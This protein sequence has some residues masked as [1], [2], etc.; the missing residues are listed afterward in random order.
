MAQR[1]R[2]MGSDGQAQNEVE[3]L[4]GGTE[5]DWER[6]GLLAHEAEAADFVIEQETDE[7]GLLRALMAEQ[8]QSQLSRSASS[9]S[10]HVLPARVVTFALH[11]HRAATSVSRYN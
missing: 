10:D 6:E 5:P 7:V 11:A 8:I 2:L 1:G 3:R 4:E 9:T